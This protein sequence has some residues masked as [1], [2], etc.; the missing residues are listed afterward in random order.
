M[1]NQEHA[2]GVVVDGPAL[3]DSG[4]SS[5]GLLLIS[6]GAARFDVNLAVAKLKKSLAQRDAH[7]LW[8]EAMEQARR[9][10][11]RLPRVFMDVDSS[12]EFEL[13]LETGAML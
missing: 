3:A 4:E 5:Q 10:G 8:A 11:R 2:L 12:G 6:Q 1:A 7:L 13:R 9:A